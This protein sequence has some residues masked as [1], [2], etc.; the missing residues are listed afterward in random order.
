MRNVEIVHNPHTPKGFRAGQ[1]SKCAP[2]D[3]RRSSRGCA[4][5]NIRL[6]EEQRQSFVVAVT[7]AN[8]NLCDKDSVYMD[9]KERI[10]V[11]RV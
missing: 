7:D 1:R 9:D 2:D 6:H 11:L 3:S 4:A 8:P 5:T 10:P